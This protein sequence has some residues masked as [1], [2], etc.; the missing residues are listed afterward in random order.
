MFDIIVI[1]GGAAGF[2]SAINCAEKN[3]FL[4]IAILEKGKEVLS[5]VKIS[6]GG[7]CNLT[8]AEFIPQN[9]VK[10]YPRGEK[11]LLSPFHRFM[12]GDVMDWFESR[13][14]ALKTEED[15]RVFPLSN[16][17][18]TII[19]CFTRLVKQLG[20]E[21]FTSQNVVRFYQSDVGWNV[22]TNTQTFSAKKLIVTT[23]SNPKI[24]KILS[25]LGHTIVPPVPSLFTFNTSDLFIKDL[26]GIAVTSKVSLRDEE[27]NSL[28][29]K[30]VAPLLI[31]HWGFSGPAIL[32]LSAWGARILAEKNYKCILEVNWLVADSEEIRTEEV[33]SILQE[34]KQNHPRK[35][36]QNT[37]FFNLPKRLWNRLL[38]KGGVNPNELWSEISKAQIRNLAQT[39][40][41]SRFK[42]EGKSTFKE[43]FVTAG[44]VSLSEINFKT[45]ESKL[46]KDLYLAG[47]IIDVDAI[48]GGFNFQNAWTGGYLISEAID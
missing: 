5:K 21:L 30:N 17:S 34:I 46:F 12:C 13:G 42:I 15:G 2:F 36:L 39:L 37:T 45:F 29:I 40:T 32:K 43:E 9:L 26:S 16:N 25:G 35:M 47:E 8:H 14:V 11:E 44:G 19:D 1:G 38:E 24:W 4:K 33:I 18:Q 28:K 27:G 31:T 3:P 22:E 7:R 20:I 10:N 23:G 48:T 6:G 41:C